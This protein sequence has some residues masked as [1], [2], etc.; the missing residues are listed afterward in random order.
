ML[1]ETKSANASTTLAAIEAFE[2]ER[3][4]VLPATYKDFLL[5]SNGGVPETP[6]FPIQGMELNPFG[7]VQVF[8][9]IDAKFSTSDLAETYDLYAGGIPAHI[10]PIASNG[11]GDYICLDLR[12]G[13]EK[14]VF[15]DK[16]PFWGT[17]E[18]RE[19]DLYHVAD[20]FEEFLGSLRPDDLLD[21]PE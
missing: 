17:G 1:L 6:I 7:G 11:M 13:G 18:W 15:W 14:V 5:A 19:S 4:L 20:S 9:G 2:R 8:F 3:D 16:R 10:V 21:A 12:G